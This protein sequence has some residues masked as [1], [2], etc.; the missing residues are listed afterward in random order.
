M[1]K[2]WLGL[3]PWQCGPNRGCEMDCEANSDVR[4]SFLS[5]V[6][7]H[8]ALFPLCLQ[9][10]AQFFTICVQDLL[11]YLLDDGGFLIMS[12]QK[13]DWNKVK[14]IRGFSAS[15]LSFTLRKAWIVFPIIYRWACSS[16]TLTRPWCT[17]STTIPSTT[18]S[19][20]LITSLCVSVCPTVKLELHPE[21]CLW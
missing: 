5:N 21:E 10:T 15:L 14:M 4:I 18:A 7:N 1:L 8:I 9:L 11:C 13:D 3:S 16:V 19:S 6:S 17:L 2:W 12:N 20:H